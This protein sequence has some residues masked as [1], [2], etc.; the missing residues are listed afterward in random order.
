M[1]AGD[2]SGG[3]G[4]TTRHLTTEGRSFEHAPGE[5]PSRMIPS[6]GIIR[7][8]Q[9]RMLPTHPGHQ[10]PGAVPYRPDAPLLPGADVDRAEEQPRIATRFLPRSAARGGP[11]IR[12][13]TAPQISDPPNSTGSAGETSLTDDSKPREVEVH[14]LEAERAGRVFPCFHNGHY[15]GCIGYS[16]CKVRCWAPRPQER[17][18]VVRVERPAG[19]PCHGCIYARPVPGD[20][21][22]LDGCKVSL[23]EC[24]LGFWYGRAALEDFMEDKIALNVTLPCPGFVSSDGSLPANAEGD[25]EEDDDWLE[26][27]EEDEWTV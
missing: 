26:E 4:N 19:S 15:T 11:A 8:A 5:R 23:M 16:Q 7:N 14:A 25:K 12:R 3:G 9:Q 17:E 6:H 10:A 13:L 18:A 27:D 24:R 2:A 1:Q 20:Y 22:V 21:A